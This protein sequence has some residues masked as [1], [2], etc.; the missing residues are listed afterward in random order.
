VSGLP[1]MDAL[2]KYK[3][4]ENYYFAMPG[5]KMGKGLKETEEGRTLL[6]NLID[7][8]ITEVEGV[9][10]LHNPTGIIKEGQ[11]K[12]ARYYRSKQ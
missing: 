6:N 2:M 10:N 7:F 8:D 1:I 5:H 11:E 12:L 4:E 3:K 9:D